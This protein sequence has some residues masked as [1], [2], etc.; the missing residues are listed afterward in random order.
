M[1]GVSHAWTHTPCGLLCL[2]PFLCV[3][4]SGS[5]LGAVRGPR[6]CSGCSHTSVSPAPEA[7]SRSVCGWTCCAQ[8][9]ARRR[10]LG[11]RIWFLDGCAVTFT[12]RICVHTCRHCPG[13]V[14]GR[15]GLTGQQGVCPR[16][17]PPAPLCSVS[18][19]GRRWALAGG[20][21]WLGFCRSDFGGFLVSP[22]GLPWADVRH[23]S[24]YLHGARLVNPFAFRLKKGR[25]PGHC[26]ISTGHLPPSVPRS[27][28]TR[29]PQ[30]G[31]VLGGRPSGA[32]FGL[33]ARL[34][35]AAASDRRPVCGP[36]VSLCVSQRP[37]TA[38]S[39]GP[40]GVVAAHG[41]CSLTYRP[42]G[43]GYRDGAGATK[44]K[45]LS[46]GVFEA[47]TR[48]Q[49]GVSSWA[50]VGLCRSRLWGR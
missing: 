40:Y 16:E 50:G 22:G 38:P 10:A 7:A 19:A 14:P 4:G 35:S 29:D 36:S 33:Y 3:V 44:P 46:S 34:G 17:E 20:P 9:L 27:Q 43:I 6:C 32:G 31:P 21:S 5:V 39:F 25:P 1:E 18:P 47:V 15:R 41:A 42:D 11:F 2:V 13:R 26:Y 45:A 49:L 48:R 8:P 28:M 24:P 30:P 12:C 23:G 37:P